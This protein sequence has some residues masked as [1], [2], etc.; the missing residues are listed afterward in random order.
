MSVDGWVEKT[1]HVYTVDRG[2]AVKKGGMAPS[3]ATGGT[4]RAL[5]WAKQ[6]RQEGTD[7]AGRLCPLVDPGKQNK[8]TSGAETDL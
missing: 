2:T 5:C 1:R 7:V 6:A 4:C 3:A 8:P